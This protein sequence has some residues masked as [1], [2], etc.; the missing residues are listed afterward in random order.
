M[1]SGDKL[2][3]IL[4]ISLA[5]IWIFLSRTMTDFSLKKVLQMIRNDL[6]ID[7]LMLS[8]EVYYDFSD[9]Y[10]LSTLMGN[11]QIANWD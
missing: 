9:C 6:Y 10:Q 7:F 11:M 2:F 5:S 1:I 4:C 3:N 8:Y